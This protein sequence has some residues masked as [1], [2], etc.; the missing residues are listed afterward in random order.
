MAEDIP[1]SLTRIDTAMAELVNETDHKTL[2]IWAISCVE[3]VL[4]VL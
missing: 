4:P 1:F 3:R 2:A